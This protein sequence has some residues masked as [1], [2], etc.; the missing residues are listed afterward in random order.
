M[1]TASAARIPGALTKFV[2]HA[3]QLNHVLPIPQSLLNAPLRSETVRSPQGVALEALVP[4]LPEF[5]CTD[6]HAPAI[7]LVPG[8]GMD[9]WGFLRQLPLGAMAHLHLLQMPNEA[10]PDEKGL[11]HFARHVEDYIRAR[12]L[13]RHPGGVIVGGC[14][15]GGA[16]SLHVATRARV[17]LRG[18]ALIGTFGHCRHL[19]L[20]QRI[21]APLAWVLPLHRSRFIARHVVKKTR[22]FGAVTS[23]EAEFL[24]NWK[25]QRTQGYF[26]RAVAALTRQ[27]Q[28]A[29][30]SKLKL[31]TLVTHGQDD[32]VLPFAAGEELA[33][34]IPNAIWKPSKEAGHAIFFTHADAVNMAVAEL[35]R[36]A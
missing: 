17:P 5:T 12:G 29:A 7:V 13:D 30:A 31:P 9:G 3:P 6:P 11:G 4:N 20:W 16:V 22:Y 36:P 33:A 32:F 26:G 21:A 28:L 23:D 19:P 15:M 34:T 8:L 24:C 2:R 1:L 27:N 14:S 18:L 35:I 25:V 10:A